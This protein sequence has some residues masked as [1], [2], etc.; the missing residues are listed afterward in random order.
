MS[1]PFHLMSLKKNTKTY[2]RQEKQIHQKF[3]V[4]TESQSFPVLP[5]F[6]FKRMFD[7]NKIF[8]LQR[9]SLK[10][11]PKKIRGICPLFC[12]IF[13]LSTSNTVSGT[14]QNK[15]N[16]LLSNS[17]LFDSSCQAFYLCQASV[18]IKCCSS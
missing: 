16:E 9:E 11:V 10:M 18:R 8:S 13:R 1:D 17:W 14:Q 5:Y 7:I 15:L 6:R 2:G 12:C 3:N 4:V